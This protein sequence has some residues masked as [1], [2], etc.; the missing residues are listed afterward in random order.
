MTLMRSRKLAGVLL[1]AVALPIGLAAQ[2]APRTG[3]PAGTQDKVAEQYR[4]FTAALAAVEQEYVEELDSDRLVYGAIEGMLRTLDP[5]SSFLDPRAYA[6]MRE[7]QQGQYFGIGI[8]IVAIDGD[9]RVTSVFE[10]SPA[11]RAGIRRG[12]V[13]AKIK[14]QDTKGWTSDQA[15]AELK[16]PKGTTVQFDIRR[17]GADT[18]IDF[19]VERDQVTIPTVRAS[20]MLPNGVGYVRLQDFSETSND[21]L[22]AALTKLRGQGMQKV[23]LDLR[24]NPGGP[25]DQ[26]I[27]VSNQ[28]LPRGDMIVYTRGRTPNADQDFHAEDNGAYQKVPLVVLVNRQS[29]SASEIVSGAMQDHDRGLVVGETTF[30][31][32][33]VQSL[34]RISNQSGLALTTGRYYTPSGR[35]IQRPWDGTFDEYLTYALRSQEGARE[36]DA[37]ELKYTDAGRK[38]YGG[39]GI[40]PDRFFGGPIEGFDPTRF[41]RMLMSRG[42]FVGFAEKFKATGDTRPGSR[43]EQRRGIARGFEVTD[44]MLAEFREFVVSERVR[45]DEEAFKKDE[46]FI[47]AMIRFEIDVD[48]F[49][50]EEARRNLIAADPQARYAQTLF[51][52]AVKLTQLAKR[53]ASGGGQ[54]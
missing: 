44:Q 40:E 5:H 16:G 2:A 17:P 41:G 9:I 49:G 30:G 20:F 31:K 50:V 37:K 22:T 38:V 27:A 10:Q 25:L 23:M 11:Y 28:F 54:P 51:D 26:A 19:T 36:H 43:G 15:V 48:L 12:D 53:P 24:D 18:L 45:M 35:L 29:A 39:G 3:R 4:I 8:S 52:E 42:L 47:R 6:Q 13:I 21:E 14:G 7:R 1:L 34:Y 33:L 32:A 46:A